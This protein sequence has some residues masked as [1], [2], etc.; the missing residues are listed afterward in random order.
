MGNSE[1]KKETE[2]K[3]S[4]KNEKSEKNSINIKESIVLINSLN[5]SLNKNL[6]EE[7]KDMLKCFICYQTAKDPLSCPKC[8]NFGCQECFWNYFQ[9]LDYK[10]CPYCKQVIYLSEMKE[11][12][13]INEIQ[14]LLSGDDDKEKQ[15][16]GLSKLIEDK[17]K[18]W[19]NQNYKIKNINER[20]EAY[21][22]YIESC[23]KIYEQ[24]FKKC[25]EL[26]KKIFD[27]HFKKTEELA[28]SF[29]SYNNVFKQSMV[30]Y[31]E[32][33]ENNKKNF[34]TKDKIKDL[35]DEILAL[36]R[37][38]FNKRDNDKTEEFLTTPINLNPSLCSYSNFEEI[39]LKY[40]NNSP[41]NY[42]LDNKHPEIGIYKLT[43][44]YD[45]IKYGNQFHCLFE[46]V[47]ENK[48][49]YF[50]ITQNK[51]DKD[52]NITVFPMNLVEHKEDKYSF[53]CLIPYEGEDKKEDT[54]IFIQALAFYL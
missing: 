36:E 17:K 25:L 19:F 26:V 5:E 3:K 16:N 33:E 39:L 35:I 8:D 52:K 12:K 14:R 6:S 53:E 50:L 38:R 46:F 41:K 24:F 4:E 32:I 20:I 29:L 31:D 21:K 2:N 34:Y 9:G 18:E 48:N 45:K 10:E 28:K 1:Q 40:P 43:Y 7:V 27:D 54:E 37:K 22:K 15:I 51:L 11:N 49:C 47:L 44:T 42:Y 23:K 30:K 13:I